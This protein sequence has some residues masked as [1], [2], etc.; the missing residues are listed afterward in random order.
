MA[1][2]NKGMVQCIHCKR[3]TFMQWFQNPIICECAILRERYV[4][5][6]KRFCEN[7]VERTAPVEVTHYNHY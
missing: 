1:E 6:A 7:F 4:A 2:K 5:E 3:G